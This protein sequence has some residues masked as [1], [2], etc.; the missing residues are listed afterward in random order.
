MSASNLE[1]FRARAD[2]ARAEGDAATLNHVRERCRR[3]E[4]A[5]SELAAKAERSERLR[6]KEAI[7]KA[8]AGL[9]S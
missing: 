8:E 4:A 2:Q 1:F 7:R 9:S 5:W 6:E 3:S